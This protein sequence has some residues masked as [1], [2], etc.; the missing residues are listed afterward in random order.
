[1][2]RNI[3][4][5][6]GQANDGT[7]DSIRDAFVKVNENF[8]YIFETNQQLADLS[9]IQSQLVTLQAGY[10]EL[11]VKTAGSFTQ[12]V[13]IISNEAANVANQVNYLVT[14]SRSEEHTSEL[15]SH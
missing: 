6:G 12:L 9:G 3:I 5:V 7:G 10:N 14:A 13:N 15:Q 4:Q 1:M 2:E 8:A 11:V